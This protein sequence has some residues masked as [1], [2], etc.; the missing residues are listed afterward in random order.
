MVGEEAVR[1]AVDAAQD[2][3]KKAY[4]SKAKDLHPDTGGDPEE[5]HALTKAYDILR[6]DGSRARYDETGEVEEPEADNSQANA[7]HLI[8]QFTLEVIN[9][10]DAI[11]MDI[12]ALISERIQ[13]E[14]AQAN[15]QSTEARKTIDRLDRFKGRV[16]SN[17]PIKAT[18]QA[19]ISDLKRSLRVFV[20]RAEVCGLALAILKNERLEPEP[21]PE[22]ERRVFTTEEAL[23]MFQD[24]GQ[25]RSSGPTAPGSSFFGY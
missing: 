23:E 3:I 22:P 20:E 6:D 13:D 17:G 9:R 14:R 19:T 2:A 12:V 7:V 8:N 11:H 15:C 24:T 21:R 5:F 10:K 25:R 4:R 18:I 16:K 1:V